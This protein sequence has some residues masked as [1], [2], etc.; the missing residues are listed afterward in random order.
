MRDSRALW[1]VPV[2][3][4]GIGLAIFVVGLA[5]W[6]RTGSEAWAEVPLPPL[7]RPPGSIGMTA[8]ALGDVEVLVCLT[9]PA[10]ERLL[11]YQVDVKRGR[12]KL[13]AA[14]DIAADW[15][16]TDWNNDPPL[17]KDIRA[18]VEKGAEGR[19][20]P[21]IEPARPAGAGENPKP[22]AAP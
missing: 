2:G 16:L 5:V 7:G 6:S 4:A 8:T 15:L 13:L 9:D 20:A 11:V 14:R 12:M 19:K 10:R 21:E 22:G 17:P 3:L 18:R 1:Y